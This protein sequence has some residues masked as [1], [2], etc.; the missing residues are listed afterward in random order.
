MTSADYALPQNRKRAYIVCM[1]R[2]NSTFAVEEC[3]IMFSRIKAILKACSVQSPTFTG[4]LL[5]EDDAVVRKVLTHRQGHPQV[6]KGWGTTTIDK[7][8]EKWAK[9]TG[10]P[11]GSVDPTIADRSSEWFQ[12]LPAREKDIIAFHQFRTK[13]D[14][15]LSKARRL[16]TD[17]HQSIDLFTW[18]AC[19]G[20]RVVLPTIL[21]QAKM[22]VSSEKPPIHRMVTGAESLNFIGWPIFESRFQDLLDNES[23][24]LMQDLAGN[25]FPTTCIL[26]CVLAIVFAGDIKSKQDVHSSNADIERAMLLFKHAR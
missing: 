20:D 18:A 8:R 16:A 10:Q 9:V 12:T 14:D 5:G 26:A 15:E 4:C 1:R 6:G 22:W 7:H 17:L 19:H 2:P 13:G 3:S 24:H 21:P 25:A 23:N 11:W